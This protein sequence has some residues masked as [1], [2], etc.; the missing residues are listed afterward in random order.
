MPKR[1]R[2][3]ILQGKAPRLVVGLEPEEY[4]TS[5]SQQQP[6]FS[7]TD[8]KKLRITCRTPTN[9]VADLHNLSA[10]LQD[11]HRSFDSKAVRPKLRPLTPG[12]HRVSTRGRL[13][14][15]SRKVQLQ[16]ASGSTRV[17]KP[18]DNVEPLRKF[19][20]EFHAKSKQL[21]QELQRRVLSPANDA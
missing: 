18:M 20:V 12:A 4:S 1:K 10:L 7:S 6:K 14:P 8:Q 15:S 13:T 5:K 16:L 11:F 3:R 19:Y 21:L 9:P 17:S 2:S